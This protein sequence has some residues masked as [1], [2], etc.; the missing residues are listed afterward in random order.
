[1]MDSEH[2]CGIFGFIIG[3]I[4]GAMLI[5]FT[6]P[7]CVNGAWERRCVARGAGTYTTTGVFK[8]KENA[9]ATP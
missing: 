4:I 7:G 5:G 3:V 1:M 8:W 6:V 2:Q 9:E